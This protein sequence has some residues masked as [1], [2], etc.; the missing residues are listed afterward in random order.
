LDL[1]IKS[2]KVEIEERILY[3]SQ[4]LIEGKRTKEICRNMSEKWKI[5]RRQVER[6]INSSYKLW[7]K[8]FKNKTKIILDYHI[9]LRMNLYRIAYEE[10]NYRNCLEILKDL[11]KL[12]GLYGIDSPAQEDTIIV[13]IPEDLETSG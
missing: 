5:S 9:A 7:H 8:E 12:E 4:L 11:A 10:E 1:F 6:Y 13:N 3:I 2:N